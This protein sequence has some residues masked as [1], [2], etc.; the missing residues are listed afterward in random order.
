MQGTNGVGAMIVAGPEGFRKNQSRK[1]NIR[2][3]ELDP[4]D[5]YG[6]MR[7]VLR[8]RSRRLLAEAPKPSPPVGEGG[9]EPSEPPGEGFQPTPLPIPPPRGGREAIAGAPENTGYADSADSESADSPWPDLVL[10][11][12]GPVQLHAPR[13]TL[14]RLGVRR[15][16]VIAIA[17]GPERDAGPETFFRSAREP[18]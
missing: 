11:A 9:G 7:E 2:T 3:A 14:G 12:G 1:F 4:G 5:D 6:M 10:I 16:A 18:F 15:L 8:R 17:K 13:E